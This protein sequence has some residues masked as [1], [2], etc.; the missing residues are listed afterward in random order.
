MSPNAPAGLICDTCGKPIT[1]VAAGWVWWIQG[2][3][4]VH[5]THHDRGC[6]PM[7]DVDA[8]D[9]HLDHFVRLGP[10]RTR[11]VFRGFGI[12]GSEVTRFLLRLAG[13]AA[14]A[15]EDAM[16]D[17]REVFAI[18]VPEVDRIAIVTRAAD[19]S[20]DGVSLDVGQAQALA[21]A[22]TEALFRLKKPARPCTTADH[23]EM[24][25]LALQTPAGACPACG[26]G[27]VEADA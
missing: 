8:L 25:R 19:G 3:P 14:A 12:P 6:A 11:E 13:V 7:T 9:H 18:A 1:T 22:I 10:R 21:A 27:I 26:A 15:G 17:R 16:S 4:L 20:V 2:G 23:A 5:I 24:L